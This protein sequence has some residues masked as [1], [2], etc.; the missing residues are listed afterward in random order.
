V[1]N[2]DD[3]STDGFAG[4]LRPAVDSLRQNLFN[5]S[6]I[7]CQL[8]PLPEPRPPLTDRSADNLVNPMYTVVSNIRFIIRLVIKL[9]LLVVKLKGLETVL[10]SSTGAISSSSTQIRSWSCILLSPFRISIVR[11][12]EPPY[13][14][15]ATVSKTAVLRFLAMISEYENVEGMVIRHRSANV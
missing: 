3:I 6:P 5:F 7:L 4:P 15:N 9:L 1:P 2:I 11:A 12:F 8:L 14:P 10:V 13:P